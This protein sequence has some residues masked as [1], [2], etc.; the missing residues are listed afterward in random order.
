MLINIF[1]VIIPLLGLI[2]GYILRKIAQEEIEPGRNY[3]TFLRKIILFAMV[4]LLLYNAEISILNMVIFLIGIVIARMIRIRYIYI[5]IAIVASLQ[6]DMEMMILLT[7][8]TSVYGLPFGTQ[9]AEKRWQTALARHA[10]LYILPLLLMWIPL[11]YQSWLP[12]FAAG[13]LFLRE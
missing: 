12:A 7:A 4:I 6:F 1:L 8:L 2:L 5:G 9:I 10:I 11:P 13:T 3:L